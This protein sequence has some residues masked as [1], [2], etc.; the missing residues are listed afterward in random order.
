MKLALHGKELGVD[1]KEADGWFSGSLEDACRYLIGQ[2]K[3]TDPE[4][5]VHPGDPTNTGRLYS[6]LARDARTLFGTK[7]LNY[8]QSQF[9]Q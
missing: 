7:S 9:P 5:L 4:H 1:F 6:E 8:N 2:M 3:R